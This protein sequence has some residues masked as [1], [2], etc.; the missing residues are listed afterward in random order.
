MVWTHVFAVPIGGI[1]RFTFWGCIF[2][3]KALYALVNQDSN[4]KW[5]QL[6]DVCPIEN[7]DDIPASYV[8]L[9]E[10]IRF[11]WGIHCFALCWTCLVE[12]AAES[13]IACS[14]CYGFDPLAFASVVVKCCNIMM[15][16]QRLVGRNHGA[17]P[18]TSPERKPEYW[19]KGSHQTTAMYNAPAC[20]DCSLKVTW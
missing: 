17:G 2:Q 15:I 11:V 4:G 3:Q 1:F 6:E 9:T 14:I 5:T 18:R 7:G 8:S 20:F 10:G 16:K 19:F 12:L 13:A